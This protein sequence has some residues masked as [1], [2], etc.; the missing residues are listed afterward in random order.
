MQ[1]LG[2]EGAFVGRHGRGLHAHQL[3]LLRRQLGGLDLR[4]TGSACVRIVIASIPVA[5]VSFGVWWA[6]DD[7]LG[8]DRFITQLVSVTAAIV[9]GAAVY[10]VACRALGVQELRALL[11]LRGRFRSA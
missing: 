7:V 5:I 3:V 10:L 6:L 8:H 9:A 4:A 2:R 1:H 11:S